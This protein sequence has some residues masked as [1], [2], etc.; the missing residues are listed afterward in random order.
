LISAT[1]AEVPGASELNGRL[2]GMLKLRGV[3]AR[4][5]AQGCGW[6]ESAPQ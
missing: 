2:C 1:L 3:L 4:Q 5:A 6:G